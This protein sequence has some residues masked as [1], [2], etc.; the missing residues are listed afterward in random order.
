VGAGKGSPSKA[1]G[2]RAIKSKDFPLGANYKIPGI[3]KTPKG[4]IFPAVQKKPVF[5]KARAGWR[6]SS[7]AGGGISF[8]SEGGG[9]GGDKDTCCFFLPLGAEKQKKKGGT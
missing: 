8:R 5:K 2:G 6:A 9:G 1:G 4:K 7:P 3:K